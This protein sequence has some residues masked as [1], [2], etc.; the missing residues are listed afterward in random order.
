VKELEKSGIGRPSTYSAIMNKIQSRDYTIKES[1]RLKPTELGTVIAAL[2]EN[3]FQLIMNIGFTAAMEDDLEKVAENQKDWKVLIR[4]FWKEFSPT[5]ETAEKEAFV[6]K[7]MTDVDCPKCGAKL[8]KIWFKNKYF[9]GCSRY[10][11][12]D[13]SA[14][15]E[16]ISFKREDYAADFDWDQKCPTCGSD[17]KVR[18]GRFGAFLGCTK[19][20]DC[21]GIV[22]I[23]KKGETVVAQ[24]DLPAC[25]ALECPG[26]MVAR[27]SR[28]GKTFYSC[29]T[30]PECDVIVNNLDDLESKYPSHP[31]TAY[32]KKAK[33]GKGKK[34]AKAAPAKKT[35]AAAKEKAP[36]VKKARTMPPVKLSQALADLVG[37]TEMARTEVTKKVWE[38]IKTH[39]LQDAANKRLI[40][41]DAALAKVFGSSEPLDMF[42]MTA[43][44]TKHMEKIS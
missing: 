6:P 12:C 36:K 7:L 20:P 8:Q 40:R 14:P 9:Y 28:F 27:K 29:S 24:G 30:F 34:E 10:P 43:V 1:G 18:H 3:N 38:Y 17:M 4:D 22:N 26:H 16:E 35:K 19:Y 5:L 11:D 41:P 2:L 33:F 23:P 42:K 21:K 13:F 32:V 44:L 25:P 31:R 37:G 39:N 15:A